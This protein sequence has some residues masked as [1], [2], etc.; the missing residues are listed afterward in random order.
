MNWTANNTVGKI[1]F[2]SLCHDYINCSLK[3]NQTFTKIFYYKV[4]V[5]MIQ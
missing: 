1:H 2:D 5:A 3:F 4:T